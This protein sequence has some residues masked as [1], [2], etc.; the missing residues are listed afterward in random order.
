MKDKFAVYGTAGFGREVMPLVRA[1]MHGAADIVFVADDHKMYGLLHNGQRIISFAEAA[2]EGRDFTIAIA[3]SEIRWKLA[4]KIAAA[5]LKFF[6][7]K[8][9]STIIYDQVEIG[10]GA[11][12]CAGV[13]I[14][15]NVVIGKQFH[16]NLYSYVAHDCRIGDFVT[17]APNVS[18]NGNVVIEDNV[19]VG[20][21]AIIKQGTPEKPLIIG[22]GAVI[23]MGAV[24][25]KSVAAGV[26]VI[27]NPAKPLIK[28][29]E[30]TN[31]S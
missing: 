21:G 25:T 7:V 26:V 3:N 12:L 15:S 18:C 9:E 19:Y 2:D 29:T 6:S 30:I 5:G 22:A 11:I 17:F 23:G 16:A 8:A 4:D 1:Q 10:E 13:I 24:V 28:Y 14:T 27:G 31:G 20:T